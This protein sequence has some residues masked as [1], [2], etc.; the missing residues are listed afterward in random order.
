MK[1]AIRALT[2]SACL[3]AAVLVLPAV[4]PQADGTAQAEEPAAAITAYATEV[5][6]EPFEKKPGA[7]LCK[8]AVKDAATGE[9][10]AGP[11]VVVPSEQA[12][13]T[14]TTTPD[15]RKILVSVTVRP[16]RKT[17]EY[18][19]DLQHAGQAI[20]LHKSTVALGGA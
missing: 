17:A 16:D 2:L 9:V 20:T 10:L 15:G 19:I 18:T 7:Y 12:A 5:S 1:T 6:I 3:V 13:N 11:A 8:V 4:L 14:E